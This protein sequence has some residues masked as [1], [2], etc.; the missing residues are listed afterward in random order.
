[1]YY[2][3]ST[4]KEDEETQIKGISL[5]VFNMTSLSTQSGNN[6][7]GTLFHEAVGAAGGMFMDPFWKL[8]REIRKLY[9]IPRL[10]YCMIASDHYNKP[11]SSR[12]SEEGTST[13]IRIHQGMYCT[14]AE[15]ICAHFLL[16]KHFLNCFSR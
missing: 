9:P 12:L 7:W 13:Q 8:W 6:P 5:V 4:A 1:M 14:S 10:H 11:Y 15:V 16:Q 3:L 2:M